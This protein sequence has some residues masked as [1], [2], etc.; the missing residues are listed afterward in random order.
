M[1]VLFWIHGGAWYYGS[2][3]FYGSNKYFMDKDLIVVSINYRLGAFG[4][5]STDDDIVPGNMGLKD[6]SLALRWVSE[7]I[8]YF[9]GDSK[10]I[11]LFG[12]SAGAASVHYHYLSPMSYGLFQNGISPSGTALDI[13]AHADNG[14]GNTDIL[15]CAVGCSD[16]DSTS[17]VKCLKKVPADEI[18]KAVSN[19]AVRFQFYFFIFFTKKILNVID[20]FQSYS[21]YYLIFLAG[22]TFR[23]H[24]HVSSS[25]RKN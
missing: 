4:F 19:I 24:I 11:T 3:S 17:I 22:E 5:L 8:Q 18:Q 7:N 1:P 13:W 6:Q 23:S 14:K 12:N 15:A 9:G 25:N 20:L 2:S 10:R 16:T 21:V